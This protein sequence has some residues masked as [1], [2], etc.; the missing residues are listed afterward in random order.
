MKKQIY[1]AFAMVF[2]MTIVTGGVYP[3]LITAI[4]QIFFKE[5]ANGSL[6]VKNGEVIGSH[7]IGQPFTGDKY[8][9]S[10]PSGA[11]YDAT[12]SSG[13]NFGPSSR[14][15]FE[16]RIKPLVS[17]YTT[18]NKSKKVPVD[19]VTSSASGLDPHITPAAA[20]Y[21]VTRVAKVRNLS[22][23]AVRKAVAKYTE[24]RQF[25]FLGEPRVNVVELNIYLDE[26]QKMVA[27]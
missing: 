16:V 20:D 11:G 12:A 27:E 15:L 14:K 26:V 1:Q 24:D 18:E 8:F 5:K 17:K 13:T 10:R 9:H 2:V 3:L 6:I 4:S 7:L 21:Q 19:L 25:G 23:D 22:E